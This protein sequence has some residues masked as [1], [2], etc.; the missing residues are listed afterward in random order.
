MDIYDTAVLNRTVR[1]LTP[2]PPS[3]FLSLFPE[4]LE[5]KTEEV[6]F[7]LATD[8]PRISPFV[9]PLLPGKLVESAGYKTKSVKPAYIKDKRVH[10]PEKGLKRRA[11]EP[12]GGN[13]TPA[14]RLQA[15]LVSDLVDQQTML[16]RRLE[17]MAAEA[18]LTGKQTINGEGFDG[19][20]VNFGRDADMTIALSGAEKWDAAEAPDMAAQ[21]EDWD[22]LL[23]SKAGASTSAVV[24][25]RKAWKLFRRNKKLIEALD[26]RKG[27]E[28]L[29]VSLMPMLAQP[30]IK[31]VGFF[32]EYPLFV[33]DHTY[34][35]PETNQVMKGMPDNT[36]SFIAGS[37]V[38]GV[39]HFG[40]IKDL[41]ANVEPMMSFTKSW[42]KKDPSIRILLMQSAPLMVPYRVNSAVTIKVA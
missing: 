29:D 19:I 31:Y 6:Y 42:V 8:K 4:I 23:L 14:Q 21:F 9:H 30:G 10:N 40:V 11:G 35:D 2:P 13:L 32:G 17:V 15:L 22:A 37:A 26:R 7:D 39:Q 24:M 16:R 1:L 28:L 27:S 5:H 25:D 38:E 12:I 33:Y 34:V 18:I 41:E 20:V 36:V 3:F